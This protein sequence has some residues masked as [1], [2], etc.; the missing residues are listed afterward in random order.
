MIIDLP[1]FL[2]SNILQNIPEP[3]YVYELLDPRTNEVRYIGKT[4]NTYKRFYEHISPSL[5]VK[6]THKNNWIK[7]LLKLN[8]RPIMRVIII[9]TFNNINK[10]EIEAISNSSNLTNIASGGQGGSPSL[11]TRKKLSEATKKAAMKGSYLSLQ[12]KV[13]V[14]NLYTNGIKIFDSLKE[15]SNTLRIHKATISAYC[16]NKRK[17]AK[18]HGQLKFEYIEVVNA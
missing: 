1:E 17:V 6:N 13:K 10:C 8:L 7:Q 5:L 4:K 3:Y 15:T 18:K 16:L 12:K 11:E 14:T 9:T 2:R